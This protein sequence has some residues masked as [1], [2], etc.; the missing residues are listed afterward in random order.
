[1][2]FMY[3]SFVLI[4]RTMTHETLLID[5]FKF[6]ARSNKR[7][8]CGHFAT[9]DPRRG[10]LIFSPVKTWSSVRF[11]STFIISIHINFMFSHIYALRFDP[12]HLQI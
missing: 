6:A 9:H 12:G 10:C 7:S 1:M 5:D 4:C 3:L 2:M 11:S 8:A